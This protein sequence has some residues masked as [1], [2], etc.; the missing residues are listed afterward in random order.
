MINLLEKHLNYFL[1]K[2]VIIRNIKIYIIG[3]F[4]HYHTLIFIFY[5]KY[6][7]K[8]IDFFNVFYDIFGYLYLID[9]DFFLLVL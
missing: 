3:L 1:I 7:N 2:T 9:D 6:N 8:N 5:K 4:G